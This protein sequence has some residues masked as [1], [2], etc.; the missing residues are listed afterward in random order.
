MKKKSPKPVAGNSNLQKAVA[1]RG[2]APPA[3]GINFVDKQIDSNDSAVQGKFEAPSEKSNHK[4]SAGISSKSIA[5]NTGLP[6]NLKTGIENLSGFSMNDVKVH[7]NSAKPAQLNA[8]AYTQGTD[9]HVAPGQEQHLPHEAWH[10]VQQKQGRVQ[11]TTQA[12]GVQV[13][14]DTQLESEADEMGAKALQLMSGNRVKTSLLPLQRKEKD[15][16]DEKEGGKNSC[17]CAQLKSAACYVPDWALKNRPYWN[18]LSWEQKNWNIGPNLNFSEGQREKI[19]EEN[20]N[21]HKPGNVIKI[22]VPNSSDVQKSD[23][24]K[25]YLVRKRALTFAIANVDHVVEKSKG[26]CASVG[27]AQVLAENANVGATYMG[28]KWI[29]NA[30]TNSLHDPTPYNKLKYN[31]P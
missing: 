7:F 6:D 26:G 2:F 11:P 20:R 17:G 3:Y 16:P 23:G 14:D 12:K 24:D 31:L 15:L 22:N 5:N 28:G 29:Y 10:V 18:L 27:N 13:N 8:L 25:S 1:G 4:S 30:D 19:L 21:I 9:I